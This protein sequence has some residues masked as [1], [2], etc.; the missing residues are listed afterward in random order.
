MG[1]VK[2]TLLLRLNS[3]D[4]IIRN[5]ETD[6]LTKVLTNIASMPYSDEPSVVQL[7]T[8]DGNICFPHTHLTGWIMRPIA[9]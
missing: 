3:T 1:A 4:F 5:D 6:Q 9:K 7:T 8:N 2:V